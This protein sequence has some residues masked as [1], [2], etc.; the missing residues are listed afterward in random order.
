MSNIAYTQHANNA[1]NTNPSLK[2]GACLMAVQVT[3]S[4][5]EAT[6]SR[7]AMLLEGQTIES[8]LEDIL[9]QTAS[10]G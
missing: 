6:L 2:D 5:G 4:C 8:E 1:V 7:A 3:G 10:V 9:S